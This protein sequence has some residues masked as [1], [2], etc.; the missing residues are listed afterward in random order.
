MKVASLLL[1]AIRRSQLIHNEHLPF[2]SH[3][4]Q[5]VTQR[6]DGKGDHFSFASR[7]YP[8]GEQFV[9]IANSLIPARMHEPERITIGGSLG[10]QRTSFSLLNIGALGYG[11][12]SFRAVEAIN[13]AASLGSFAQNTGEEGVVSPHRRHGGALILQLGTD[14][15]GCRTGDGGFDPERF[16]DVARDQQVKAIE[17]KLSQGAKPGH[18]GIIPASKMSRRLANELGVE[19]HHVLCSPASHSAFS[20]LVGLLEFAKSLAQLSGGKPVGVKLCAGSPVSILSLCRAMLDTG[21]FPDFLVLDGAEGG[22]GAAPAELMNHVGIPLN[23]SLYIVNQALIGCGIR[24]RLRIVASGKIATGYDMFRSI[25][26]GADLCYS[27]RAAMI[28]MGCIQTGRCHNNKCP[29]G[30]ATQSAWR[31]RILN[32]PVASMRVLRFHD[33]TVRS[34]MQ[35][36]SVAGLDSVSDVRREHLLERRQA[37]STVFAELPPLEDGALVRGKAPRPWASFWNRSGGPDA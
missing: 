18:G 30:I 12:L 14:Y 25:A 27:A 26:L 36:L 34:L 19:P 35:L 21:I 32:V 24:E 9:G 37:A 17:I 33:A 31:G 5:L 15:F 13:R 28:A 20:G 1:G 10:Y 29:V 3:V 23:E 2:D 7:P 22:T 4:T 16:I 6:A 8:L 11:P